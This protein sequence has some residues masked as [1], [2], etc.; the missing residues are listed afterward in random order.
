MVKFIVAFASS[1]AYYVCNACMECD[2]GICLY[3]P[4]IYVCMHILFSHQAGNDDN[5]FPSS[6][7]N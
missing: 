7:A 3:T 1:R 2:A 5:L 6:E 4:G